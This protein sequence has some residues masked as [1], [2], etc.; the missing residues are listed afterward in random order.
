MALELNNPSLKML[1]VLE[2]DPFVD[3]R[4]PDLG[5]EVKVANKPL[6]YWPFQQ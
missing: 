1:P 6:Y 2:T 3:S 5:S 4:G